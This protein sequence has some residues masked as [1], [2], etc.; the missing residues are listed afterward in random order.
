MSSVDKLCEELRLTADV[1][2]VGIETGAYQVSFYKVDKDN[3]YVNDKGE[4][5][6]LIVK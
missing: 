6:V 3:I 2:K 1:V 5:V 4:L